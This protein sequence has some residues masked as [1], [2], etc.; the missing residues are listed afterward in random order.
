MEKRLSEGEFREL[1]EVRLSRAGYFSCVLQYRSREAVAWYA[2]LRIGEIIT[3]YFKEKISEVVDIHLNLQIIKIV[4]KLNN[5]KKNDVLLLIVDDK[6]IEPLSQY[7]I[8]ELLIKKKNLIFISK[9]ENPLSR[10]FREITNI[11]IDVNTLSEKKL[12]CIIDINETGERKLQ[13]TFP[14]RSLIEN[15]HSLHR[16]LLKQS[17][18]RQVPELEEEK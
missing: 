2:A 16:A 12:N 9:Q 6:Y 7:L 4:D 1:I 17:I 5:L 13:L 8:G 14:N 10:P 11:V 18:K 3:N 15:Y